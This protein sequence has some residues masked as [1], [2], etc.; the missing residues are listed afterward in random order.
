MASF[1]IFV[2]GLILIMLS[3]IMSAIPT[4]LLARLTGTVMTIVSVLLWLEVVAGITLDPI[5]ATIGGSLSL[6]FGLWHYALGLILVA[7]GGIYAYSRKFTSD[8]PIKGENSPRG[9]R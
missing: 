5:L 4:D 1:E 9:R 6:A 8:S 2:M 7:I 3:V